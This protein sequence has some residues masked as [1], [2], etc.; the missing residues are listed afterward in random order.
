MFLNIIHHPSIRWFHEKNTPPTNDAEKPG[1]GRDRRATLQDQR[2]LPPDFLGYAWFFHMACW[3]QKIWDSLFCWSTGKVTRDHFFLWNF[4]LV[5]Y[6]WIRRKLI[7]I[8]NMLAWQFSVYTKGRFVGYPFSQHF[9]AVC[10]TL[11]YYCE[12]MTGIQDPRCEPVEIPPENQELL[13]SVVSNAYL[14]MYMSKIPLCSLFA[15]WA[16][17]SFP[18]LLELAKGLNET[19]VGPM[20]RIARPCTWNIPK[21]PKTQ[22]MRL[23][24]PGSTGSTGWCRHFC[25]PVGSSDRGIAGDS[26]AAMRPEEKVEKNSACIVWKAKWVSIFAPKHRGAWSGSCRRVQWPLPMMACW[27]GKPLESSRPAWNIRSDKIKSIGWRMV[28]DFFQCFSCSF[29]L[30]VAIQ[31]SSTSLDL[32]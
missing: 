3:H 31:L 20:Q 12:K 29:D 15:D 21:L 28:E 11:L 19:V 9:T 2:C 7:Q 13:H 22:V 25:G 6:N 27:R 1:G 18:S 30:K 23:H 24:K 32:L 8:G 17:W 10:Q 14:Y 4:R 26:P 5:K 16:G